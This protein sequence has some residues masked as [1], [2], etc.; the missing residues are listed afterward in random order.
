VHAEPGGS[1]LHALHS[2][3]QRLLENA[4]FADLNVHSGYGLGGVSVSFS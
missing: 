3:T 1:R 4:L 2:E